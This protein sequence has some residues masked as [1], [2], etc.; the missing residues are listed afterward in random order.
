MERRIQL[1][2][3]LRRAAPELAAAI[4]DEFLARHPDWRE[5]YGE[6]AYTAGVEDAIFHIRFLAGA[7]EAGAPSAFADYARW[8]GRVLSARGI[9]TTFLHE[10]LRQVEEAL[11]SRVSEDNRRIAARYIDAAL[12]ALAAPGDAAE[13][14]PGVT[15]RLYVQALLGGERRAA[16][17]IAREA[18]ATGT[19]LI[20]LYIDVFQ[21]A[22]YEVGR[23]WEANRIT[24]AQ[25]HMATAITQYVMAQTY[26]PAERRA[27]PRGRLLMSGVEGELH[28]VGAVMVSDVL[29]TCGWEVRFVGTDLPR[30]SI[31][32]AIREEQPTHLGLSVTMVF[33]VPAVRLLLQEVRQQFGSAIHVLVGGAAFRAA[34][35]LWR[36]VGAD[37][38]APDLRSAQ[39]LLCA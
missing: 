39:Q 38:F 2:D 9:A 31:L 16:L 12:E 15:S 33:N 3:A 6:R 28:S 22:L 34:G 25:E 19:S 24:V 26:Q 4:T 14:P 27:S 1:A 21:S 11:A 36:E 32:A 17:Q 10:N 7:I 23:L 13:S 8:T 20:E 37:G 29:E 30:A 5:R 35:E 18:L